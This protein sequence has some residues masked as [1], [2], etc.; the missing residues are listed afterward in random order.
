MRAIPG[1]VVA[2]VVLLALALWLRPDATRDAA[3]DGVRVASLLGDPQLPEGFARATRPGAIRL[4]ADH[5]PHPGFQSEWWYFTGHLDGPVGD[6]SDQQRRRFGFQL[7]FF[8]FATAPEPPERESAW[9][10]NQLYM[11][12]FAITDVDGQRHR[13]A[14]RF[15]RG[16]AG[17]AGARAE[18]FEVWLDDWQAVSRGESFLPLRLDARDADLGLKLRVEPGK[19]PVLQG[20]QGLS[21]KGPEPGNASYYYSYTRLPVSGLISL[22]GDDIAVRGEAWLDREW[23]S[24]SLGAGVQGWD[25]FGLQLDDGRELMLYSLRDD[26]GNPTRFSAATL[27]AADGRAEHFPVDAFELV[28]QRRWRSANTGVNWPVAWQLRLPAAGLDL[29]IR[30]LVDDQ[31]QRVAVLYWEGAVEVRDRRA[32]DRVGRGYLEMTGYAAR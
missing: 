6:Q 17:L 22:G 19:P 23:S 27:V 30:A 24:S 5:G 29:E 11:A 21:R 15:S 1:L 20:D 14:E 16:A 4:P 25:W 12:H 26:S 9:A 18:P 13:V 10:S 8:R 2:G 32:G 3:S 28:A 7:T 31:E